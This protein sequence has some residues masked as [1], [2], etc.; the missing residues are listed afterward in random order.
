MVFLFFVPKP[1]SSSSLET[2]WYCYAAV[3]LIWLVV[4]V[5]VPV[6]H[7]IVCAEMDAASVVVDYVVV[8]YV[9]VDYVVVDFGDE[10]RL[11]PPL[12]LLLP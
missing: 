12:L 2:S 1:N 7:D 5:A 9:V 8:D 6:R 3:T 11:L 10:V 4:G